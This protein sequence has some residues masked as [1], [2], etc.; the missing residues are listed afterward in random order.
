LHGEFTAVAVHHF[1]FDSRFFPQSVRHTG[2][3]FSGAASDRAFAN[4]YLCHG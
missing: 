3:M 1:H 2:G 4:G